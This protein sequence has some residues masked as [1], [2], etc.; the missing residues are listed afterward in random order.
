MMVR[1]GSVQGEKDVVETLLKLVREV[2]FGQDPH[3][4][5][6]PVEESFRESSVRQD[7]ARCECLRCRGEQEG[8]V[9]GAGKGQVWSRG[10]N[11]PPRSCAPPG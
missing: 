5:K 9:R 1:Q 4:D 2:T 6:E 10:H 7:P 3:D 11:P 8:V